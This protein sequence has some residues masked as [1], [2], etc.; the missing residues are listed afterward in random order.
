HVT[1]IRGTAFEQ[2]RYRV[3]PNGARRVA[4]IA[5]SMDGKVDIHENL[6]VIGEE[7]AEKGASLF[8]DDSLF[9]EAPADAA[10]V[11]EVFDSVT[12]TPP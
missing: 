12:V 5:V 9:A 3:D 2:W 8:D 6:V 1:V 7:A 4:V 11:E 10:K